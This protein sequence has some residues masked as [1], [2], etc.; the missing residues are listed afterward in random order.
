MEEIASSHLQMKVGG[1]GHYAKEW[2][3]KVIKLKLQMQVMR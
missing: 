1:R 3:S 2:F